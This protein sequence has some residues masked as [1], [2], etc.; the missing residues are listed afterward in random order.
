MRTRQQAGRSRSQRQA[1]ASA[2]QP[3]RRSQRLAD[4]QQAHQARSQTD[5]V[6]SAACAGEVQAAM[7]KSRANGRRRNA[8]VAEGCRTVPEAPMPAR[9]AGLWDQ[10]PPELLDIVLELCCAKKLAMLETT[11]SFFRRT[12]TIQNIAETRLRAIP[13]AKGT[14]PNRKCAPWL[15]C[16]ACVCVCWQ[17]TLQLAHTRQW[18]SGSGWVYRADTIPAHHAWC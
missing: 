4:R 6:P 15:L 3:T 16:C 2:Q 18:R 8:V 9:P 10:L 13:R 17:Q 1:A 5:S 12:K 14:V 11:C 7:A